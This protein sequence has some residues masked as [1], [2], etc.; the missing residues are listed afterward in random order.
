MAG[1]AGVV[2]G[3]QKVLGDLDVDVAHLL[4]LDLA[5]LFEA[6]KD[7]GGLAQLALGGFHVE[8]DDAGAAAGAFI[9][10]GNKAGHFAVLP[11][12]ALRG[13]GEIRIAEAV[14]EGIEDLFRREGLEIPVADVDVLLLDVPLEGP[15]V[16]RGGIIADALC[17]GVG[18]VA[19][20][21][22]VAA[23]NVHDAPAAFL[24]ALPDVGDGGG[25]I[26]LH[27]G[28]VDD[29]ADVEEHNGLSEG[30]C[31]GLQHLLLVLREPPAARGVLVVLVLAGGAA[32]E[33]DGGV[34]CLGGVAGDLVRDGHFSLE[35]GLAGPALAGIEGVVLDPGV[36]E[37]LKAALQPESLV[38]LQGFLHAHDI[39]GVDHAARAGAAL[40]VVVLAAT[41]E[42]DGGAGCEGQGI[43]VI[44]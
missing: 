4:R 30:A 34:G 9:F 7:A 20:R 17:D 25:I 41:E 26:L 39:A 10:H 3:S 35:P 6:H 43:V 8:L 36:V 14:A 18:Q 1:L 29:I 5:G 24:T 38:L 2:I 32:D 40:V 28:H 33:D 21:V 37:A 22:H 31:D 23:Q 11:L 16:G 44:F 13:D 42:G 27:P 19:V 12:D 15:E